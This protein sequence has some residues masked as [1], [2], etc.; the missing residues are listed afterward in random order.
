MTGRGSPALPACAVL[1]ALLWAGGCRTV[2]APDERADAVLEADA[3][4][5]AALAQA[6]GWALGGVPVALADDALTRTSTLVVERVRPRDA[7]G[8][9]LNGRELGPAEHFR[10][11]RTGARCVLV[12]EEGGEA[13]T[14]AGVGCRPVRR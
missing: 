12:H 1:G 8:L 5:H 10:L 4:A 6:V 11:V 14:L 13:F 7:R 3:A 9:P 2:R